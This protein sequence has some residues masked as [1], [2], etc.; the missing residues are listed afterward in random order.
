MNKFLI[1]LVLFAVGC[2]GDNADQKK[3]KSNAKKAIKE[4]KEEIDV[5][6]LVDEINSSGKITD[7]QAE[8]LSKVEHLNLNGL[9]SITDEQAESLSKV[10]TF[11]IS[12]ACQKQ[13]AKYR[14]Q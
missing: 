1:M 6:A 2:G 5:D 12:A 3:I 14:K 4:S 10:E 7:R 9:T 13:I 11:W 8:S